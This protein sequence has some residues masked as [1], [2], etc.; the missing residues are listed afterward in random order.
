MNSSPSCLSRPAACS[1]PCTAGTLFHVFRLSENA[2]A[3]VQTVLLRVS[4]KNGFDCFGVGDSHACLTHI[5]DFRCV[6]WVFLLK[7]KRGM[8]DPVSPACAD[9]KVAAGE[10]FEQAVNRMCMA[11]RKGNSGIVNET[12][13]LKREVLRRKG[14]SATIRA[15]LR[16]RIPCQPAFQRKSKVDGW[17]ADVAHEQSKPAWCGN[18]L[19][20]R[21]VRQRFQC[22][23]KWEYFSTEWLLIVVFA[24]FPLS[25][26]IQHAVWRRWFVFKE[27]I[28]MSEYLFTSES[29]Y[30][31][32]IRTK[33]CDRVSDVILDAILCKY[34]DP[35][36]RVAAETLVNTGLCVLA[37]EITTTAQVD[38][39][40]KSHV[41]SSNASAT[42]PRSWA[43]DASGCAVGV[44]YD[45]QSCDIFCC[46]DRSRSALTWTR[47]LAI[48]VLMFGYTCDETSR[49]WCRLLSITA[50]AWC[51]SKR[52]TQRR[53]LPYCARKA[54]LTVVYD[55]EPQSKTHWYRRPLRNTT[56]KSVG[57]ELKTPSLEQIIARPAVWTA[58]RRNQIPDSTRPT[59]SSSASA[60]RLRFDQCKSSLIPT[61]ARPARRRRVSGR[62]PV[63][64]GLFRRLRL[65]LRCENIVAVRYLSYPMPNPSF[66][67][68]MRQLSRNRLRFPSTLSF[69]HR[70][71]QRGKNWLLL[72]QVN[73]SDLRLK[74]IVQQCSISCARFY[75][76]SAA[77]GHFC[78]E[79]PEFIW[80]RTWQSCCIEGGSGVVLPVWKSEKCRLNSSDGI[81][82]SGFDKIR[83]RRR[84]RRQWTDI[85]RQPDSLG[86]LTLRASPLVVLLSLR[87]GNAFPISL[88]LIQDFRFPTDLFIIR[89]IRQ[90]LFGF[91]EWV[92]CIPRV[93]SAKIEESTLLIL[94]LRSGA[95][96]TFWK[97]NVPAVHI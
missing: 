41:R 12:C 15:A 2:G 7:V 48:V 79:E 24:I 21:N 94:R 37:G 5:G 29:R 33:L 32:A 14:F 50:T 65:P 69:C 4:G 93:A 53:P 9:R 47:A 74:R 56:R 95:Y 51:T 1:Q 91:H 20:V 70:Q 66:L 81:L 78:R 76:K 84:S 6:R 57:E 17:K 10:A 88:I 35:Q 16:V 73:I 71:N 11:V 61:A 34:K 54:Q 40:S 36:A 49:P 22:A 30:P 63:Q 46:V 60:R 3:R 97:R 13:R 87:R 19:P 18:F 92:F 96:T 83:T 45:Q 68:A 26:I 82:G 27:I 67:L 86:L 8:S 39:T 89:Y 72:V 90:A 38:Y 80:E 75:S 52:I 42:T 44:Y 62:R 59:A 85:I 28:S 43:F 77:Y 23:F 31:K 55:S 58:D 64:S 25:D